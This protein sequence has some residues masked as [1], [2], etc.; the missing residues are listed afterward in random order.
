[1]SMI[2]LYHDIAS[3]AAFAEASVCA[4]RAA[5]KTAGEDS[6]PFPSARNGASPVYKPSRWEKWL[7]AALRPISGPTL[8]RSRNGASNI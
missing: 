8:D 6:P 7:G 2:L 4:E 3:A 5:P 1:M